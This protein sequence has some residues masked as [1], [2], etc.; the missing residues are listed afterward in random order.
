LFNAAAII[1]KEKGELTEDKA[2]CRLHRIV[3]MS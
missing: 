1:T 2:D 3:T